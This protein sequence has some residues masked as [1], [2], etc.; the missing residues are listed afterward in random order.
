MVPQ[1]MAEAHR[2]EGLARIEVSKDAAPHNWNH[3]V[4]ISGIK[5]REA[6]RLVTVAKEGGAS[7]SEWRVGFEPVPRDKWLSVEVWDGEEWVAYRDEP[8][9]QNLWA[10]I[11]RFLRLGG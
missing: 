9:R 6:R 5:E 10:L 1:T 3:F 2:D 4:A 7:P 8:K 11:K